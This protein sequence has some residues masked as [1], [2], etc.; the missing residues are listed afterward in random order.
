MKAAAGKIDKNCRIFL[1]NFLVL[2]RILPLLQKNPLYPL[3]KSPLLVYYLPMQSKDAA[4][5]IYLWHFSLYLQNL[6]LL[7]Q[8]ER[9]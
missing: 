4:D 9:K 1:D 7:L 3:D 5:T 8:N 6:F 2:R